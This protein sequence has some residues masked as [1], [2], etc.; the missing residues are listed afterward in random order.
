MIRYTAIT[1][2]MALMTGCATIIGEPMQ[3]LPLESD[4]DGATVVIVDETGSEVFRGETPTSVSLDKSD[5][6]Y[7]G[8]KSYT[9]S[10]RKDGYKDVDMEIDTRVSLWYV[11]GN[12][13]F[14]GL[15]GWL[16]VD[17]LNGDM[18]TLSQDAVDQDLEADLENSRLGDAG[19]NIAMLGSVPDDYRLAL[20]RLD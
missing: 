4:P 20:V 12:L 10:I 5:G 2:G 3:M 7:F 9:I 8:G 19:L 1:M 17:P 16:I 18:Y 14:G 15:I 6:S 11:G 13:L